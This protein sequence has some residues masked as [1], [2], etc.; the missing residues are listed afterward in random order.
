MQEKTGAQA[1]GPASI[2]NVRD[3]GLR[4]DGEVAV[5][6]AAS[7]VE[8]EQYVFANRIV[9]IGDG[10]PLPALQFVRMRPKRIAMF[11][12]VARRERIGF[13]VCPVGWR[14]GR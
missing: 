3:K 8:E 7:P 5:K 2:P 13:A 14:P 12:E 1:M 10:K 11:A 6:V 9:D 4:M